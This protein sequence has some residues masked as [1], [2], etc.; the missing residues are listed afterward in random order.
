MT[1][2]DR[3]ETLNNEEITV[4]RQSEYDD[5]SPVKR[6]SSQPSR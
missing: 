2:Q 1:S 3:V 4:E 5:L 6:K